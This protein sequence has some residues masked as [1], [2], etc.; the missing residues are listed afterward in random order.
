MRIIVPICIVVVSPEPVTVTTDSG[1]HIDQ[2]RHVL[3]LGL[4]YPWARRTSSCYTVKW[5]QRGDAVGTLFIAVFFCFHD[6]SVLAF[7]V[8]FMSSVTGQLQLSCTDRPLRQAASE[9]D[10]P[11]VATLTVWLVGPCFAILLTAT[12]PVC[13]FFRWSVCH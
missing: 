7:A 2:G 9:E 5:T 11:A 6:F 3:R 12:L 4:C 10:V 8:C 1:G 13:F